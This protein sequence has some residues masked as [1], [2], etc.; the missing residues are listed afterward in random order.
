MPTP[1]DYEELDAYL[2]DC[3][4]ID[5]LQ[6]NEEFIRI[7][8]DLAYW[9]GKYADALREFLMAKINKDRVKGILRIDCRDELVE[10]GKKPTEGLVNDHVDQHEDYIASAER[11]AAAETG[12]GRLYG[13]L[14]AVRSKKE[15]L[16][17]LG[18]HLRAEMEHDPLI[19]DQS[20]GARK[21]AEEG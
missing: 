16:I 6:I 14:D 11:L 15:M 20:R 12:K 17:S 13:V 3:V 18:A 21:R 4:H 8:G 19:R 10:A 5:P 9:N 7:P 1:E 2:R